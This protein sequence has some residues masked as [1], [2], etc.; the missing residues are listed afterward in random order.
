M[1]VLMACSCFIGL[2][3]VE[4]VAGI[5]VAAAAAGG[6]RS[7]MLAEGS[8]GGM[9]ESSG[10]SMSGVEEVGVDVVVAPSSWV[11]AEGEGGRG[12]I[13]RG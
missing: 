5:A 1:C 6:E 8:S 2:L 10:L 11:E 7:I 13:A 12:V 3:C 4:G 9:R